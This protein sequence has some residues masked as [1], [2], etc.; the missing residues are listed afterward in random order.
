MEPRDP[1]NPTP[2]LLV[3]LVFQL[4]WSDSWQLLLV[5]TMNLTCLAF[6]IDAVS[7]FYAIM[8]FDYCQKSPQYWPKVDD[9]I[10]SIL[11]SCLM[12]MSSDWVRGY[13]IVHSLFSDQTL[14]VTVTAAGS[15]II[16]LF[17]R[18]RVESTL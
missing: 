9:V 12:V 13:C 6:E 4:V 11:V 3:T 17:V 5:R 15:S 2:S 1:L 10:G 18:Q 8:Q 14:I 7:P 16:L